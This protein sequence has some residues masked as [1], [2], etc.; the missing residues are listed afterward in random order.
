MAKQISMSA[1]QFATN[2]TGAMG[3]SVQKVKDGINRVTDSPMAK[4]AANKDKW[5]DGVVRAYNEGRF[6]AGL[7]QVSLQ[8]WKTNTMAKVSER[9]A[10][11][12]TAAKGKMTKF[13]A[14]LIPTVNQGLQQI[15]DMPKLTLSDSKARA[16]AW[17][18]FMASNAYK[19]A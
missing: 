14:W 7:G 13:G 6:E 5:R 15:A 1:D 2:W 18:D 17:I 9:L 10:S 4:A 8:D 3:N 16:V 12:A 11:G 19:K